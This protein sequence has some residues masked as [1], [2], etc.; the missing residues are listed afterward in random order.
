[1]KT[2]LVVEDDRVVASIYRSK[3]QSEGYDVDVAPDGE[4]AIAWLK[5]RTPN[6]VLL[7]IGLPK[8]NGIEVLKAIRSNTAIKSIPVIVLSNS[9]VTAL[10]QA[11]WKEGA[12]KCLSKA[13][14]NPRIIVD[15]VHSMI[16]EASV[17][18]KNPLATPSTV[19]S[20]ALPPCPSSIQP[21]ASDALFQSQVRRSLLGNAPGFTEDLRK[22][23]KILAQ[24]SPGYNSP[25]DIFDFY[26][27]VHAL[28]GHAGSA[29]F[30]PIAHL[31]SALEALL[32]ELHEK[33]HKIGP[34]PIR[35][36]AQAIDA[37]AQLF[38]RAHFPQSEDP[39]APLVLVLDDDV[40]A[41][42]AL[43]SALDKA[44]LRSISV[45]DPAVAVRL[46]EENSFNLIFSDVEMPGLNGFEFC[47]K[48]RTL[49]RHKST[50]L[51]FVTSLA[52]FEYRAKST[53][54][55]GTD[56]IAKPFLL[57]ELAVKALTYVSRENATPG[58]QNETSQTSAS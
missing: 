11:A 18:P 4:A 6:L 20:S 24:Q 28:T 47:A 36:V 37:L 38:E 13:D 9:Y 29:G 1:M 48:A 35:T 12:N 53:L 3:L 55:G 43:C 27:A 21:L 17:P 15:L 2:I 41:R 23:L 32:K 30:S 52:D 44:N 49:P 40:F 31:C 26:C 57:V 19:Q 39:R 54:S 22:R 8:V 56:L 33:P 34:S 42:G 58:K 16:E 45:D 7:D 51:V 10:V 25:A 5:S 46:L 50:P 14:S